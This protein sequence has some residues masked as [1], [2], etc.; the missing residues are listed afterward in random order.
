MEQLTA[1]QLS[2]A[3]RSGEI[4]VLE[5]TE[6]ALR[7]ADADRHGAFVEVAHEQAL[8]QAQQ[9]QD[10]LRDKDFRPGPLFGVPCPV[11]DLSQVSGM[12]FEAGS[13]VYAGQRA[14]RDDGVVTRI[15]EAGMVILG[16]TTTPEFGLPC[17]TE[18]EGR[19][20][21]VTP[22]DP[23]RMAGGSSGGAAAA[24]S[25][26]VVPIAHGSDGG[27]SI[28]IPASCC[29]LV[30]LKP[31]RGRISKG[32]HGV[33]G[34]A[35]SSEGVLTRDVRDTAAALDALSTGWPGD[36]FAAPA[37][38]PGGFL[39]ACDE[40][41]GRLRI[42][43]LSEPV[44]SDEAEVHPAVTQAVKA[45]VRQ[46]SALGHEVAVARKPF[47]GEEWGA[48]GDLW[49]VGALSVPVPEGAEDS[50]RPLT[51]WLRDKGR[52]CSALGFAA[53]YAGIQQITRRTEQAWVGFDV[54]L[55]P[56]LAQPPLPVGALRN[57]AD[58]AADFAAQT[59][60]T[61]W[62]SVWNLTGRPSLSLP[63]HTARIDGV[64]LP[65]GIMLGGGLGEEAR[66]L[67]LAAQLE[68]TGPNRT[69][70]TETV[71]IR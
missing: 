23:T 19:P 52:S 41:P 12:V 11:K 8:T 15:R 10:R 46:L 53:A 30:G 60:F 31:S 27:G 70:R 44:I 21:A 58:P 65:I 6:A 57:D 37:G 49:A 33:D 35:I 4:G 17:Y 42:G 24:V 61:P 45:T 69:Q 2:T 5:A 48:F 3:I 39:A 62:T 63:L 55:S 51:R 7:R 38:A 26:G 59:D 25:G 56:T 36:F 18:P 29:G 50:L 68:A 20:V 54:I 14:E 66:L 32:P 34:A 71:R 40:D 1:V 47:G 43:V 13:A 67:A 16:K 64:E 9:L 28:R 22:W